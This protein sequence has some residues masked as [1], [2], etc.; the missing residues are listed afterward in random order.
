MDIRSQ[1]GRSRVLMG[2][3]GAGGTGSSF[4]DLDPQFEG[5]YAPCDGWCRNSDRIF[6]IWFDQK[7]HMLLALEAYLLFPDFSCSSVV[8]TLL[9]YMLAGSGQ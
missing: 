9:V 6:W 1:V 4:S 7:A 3:R 8:H 2:T 5:A